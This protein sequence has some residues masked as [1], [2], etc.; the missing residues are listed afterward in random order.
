MPARNLSSIH[1]RVAGAP[2]APTVCGSIHTNQQLQ[3]ISC[4]YPELPGG[5]WKVIHGKQLLALQVIQ[6]L[7]NPW[8]G[9]REN[10]SCFIQFPFAIHTRSL[11]S[12]FF[13]SIT[14]ETRHYVLEMTQ[15]PCTQLFTCS[16]TRPS[17]RILSGRGG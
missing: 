17:F 6:G 5:I 13:S 1:C 9:G 4:Y 8:Q 2:A 7:I 14:G 16:C 3:S 15:P 12:G 10:H 11:P